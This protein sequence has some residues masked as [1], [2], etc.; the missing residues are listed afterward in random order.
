MKTIDLSH[1]QIQHQDLLNLV[2]SNVLAEN[3]SLISLDVS[4]NPGTTD[5]IR[6]KIALDMLRNIS[7]Q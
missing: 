6:Q 7:G 1:N 2:N 5:E 3:N 4:F